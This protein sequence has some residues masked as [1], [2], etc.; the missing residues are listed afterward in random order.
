MAT[1]NWSVILCCVTAWSVKGT[2]CFQ[3]RLDNILAVALSLT[4]FLLRQSVHPGHTDTVQFLEE[5]FSSYD[6]VRSKSVRSFRWL[7]WHVTAA[8]LQRKIFGWFCPFDRLRSTKWKI[9][10]QRTVLREQERRSLQ[11]NFQDLGLWFSKT[12]PSL[13]RNGS[14]SFVWPIIPNP[15]AVQFSI[16]YPATERAVSLF[17]FF[18]KIKLGCCFAEYS[19]VL[20]V[21]LSVKHVETTTANLGVDGA[22]V[23]ILTNNLSIK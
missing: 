11:D 19:L 20:M 5:P 7:I 2:E 9:G 22:S 23:S 6:I 14:F 17:I 13:F 1:D 3:R 10:L 18:I 15:N 21:S 4:V 8:R 16:T 12:A